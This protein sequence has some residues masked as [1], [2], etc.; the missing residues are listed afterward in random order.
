[1]SETREAVAAEAEGYYDSDDAD[2]FYFDI[3]GGEDIHIGLYDDEHPNIA[4][5]SRRT[6]EKMA[7]QITGLG[8]DTRVLDL[9]A[10]YGGSARLI[11]REHRCRVVCLNISEVQNERNREHNTDQG[12]ADLIDVE[13]GTFED[14][15]ADDDS[16]DVVWSQDAFLHSG[17]RVRVVEEIDRVL[18]PGGQVVFTDPMQTDDCPDGVLQPILDRIHLDSLGS[19]GF[20]QEEFQKRGYELVNFIDLSH[21]LRNHYAKV[22]EVLTDKAEAGEIRA[23]NDYVERMKTGL[24]HWV[25]G[26]DNGYLA[27]GILHFRAS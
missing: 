21:Q 18:R 7:E 10:G 8:K 12:L 16:F 14:V 22:R 13:H 15:P 3:W 26:A 24:G 1:M 9:G 2:A 6:V 5:A 11:A 23:S 17:D 4:D 19:P 20:Y 27:W 25:D